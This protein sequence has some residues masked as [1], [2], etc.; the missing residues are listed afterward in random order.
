[1]FLSVAQEQIQI[2]REEQKIECAAFWRRIGGFAK[3]AR[4]SG[5]EKGNREDAPGRALRNHVRAELMQGISQISH[6][7]RPGGP[8][9]T[10]VCSAFPVLRSLEISIV[11]GSLLQPAPLLFHLDQ[12]STSCPWGG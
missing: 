12:D 4:P 6:P 9:K 1:M 10:F 5:I 2:A 3:K 8:K 11:F 7:L